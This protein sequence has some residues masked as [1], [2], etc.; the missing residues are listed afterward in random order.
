MGGTALT[1]LALVFRRFGGAG[2]RIRRDLVFVLARAITDAQRRGHPSATVTHVALALLVDPD[3]GG[4]LETR[5][6]PLSDLYADIEALL[7]TGELL[8]ASPAEQPA[9]Q[10]DE[11][12]GV[13]L[14]RAGR[15]GLF[16]PSPRDVLRALLASKQGALCEVFAR[17]GVTADRPRSRSAAAR[18]TTTNEENRL[19]LGPYRGAREGCEPGDTSVVFW[20]DDKTKME[21][22][23]SLLRDVFGIAEPRATRLML[24]VDRDG[25]CV[26]GTY[27][28]AE[29]KRMVETALAVA[30]DSGAPLRIT[31]EE[32]NRRD[33]RR[34]A[35]R[36]LRRALAPTHMP[37]SAKEVHKTRARRWRAAIAATDL[38]EALTC[39]QCGSASKR[40]RQVDDALVCMSCSRSFARTREESP[41]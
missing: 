27:G 13:L 40:Y 26:V 34:V 5:G 28:R 2:Y 24:T 23:I 39:P 35:S 21:L 15:D 38:P 30:K 3:V 9:P 19:D 10:V 14:R 33:P 16:S 36:W 29:A 12:V 20:N 18:E 25:F 1:A 4:D 7:P 41:T 11:A 31:I 32:A 17:H 6:V 22:V 8:A 37:V